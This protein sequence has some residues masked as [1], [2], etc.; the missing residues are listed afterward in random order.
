MSSSMDDASGISWARQAE[1]LKGE[2]EQLAVSTSL[3]DARRLH[4][5]AERK[6]NRYDLYSQG[7]TFENRLLRWL[8]NF[9]SKDR[10]VAMT[11][12]NS[13]TFINQFEMKQLAT[14]TFR[15]IRETLGGQ[16]EV[17]HSDWYSYVD[18]RNQG[19]SASLSR[20]LFI[21]VADDV[22][23]DYFRRYT[24][25]V[26][27]ALQRDNFVEYYKIDSSSR[28]SLPPHDFVFL[29]DQLSGSGTSFL[30]RENGRWEG[31][32]PRFAELWKEEMNRTKIY[33]CPYIQSS[34][35]GAY[36]AD[37]V[38]RWRNSVQVKAAVNVV[39]TMR[40]P[41][42]S[43]LS[44][45]GVT[46][47]VNSEVARLCRK[48]HGAFVDDEHIVKGGESWYGFGRAGLTL[49]AYTNCPNNS[50]PLL[51]HSFGGWF[52]LFPRVRHHHS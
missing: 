4:F 44:K 17:S 14:S 46:I 38:P 5:L 31:K 50:L 19:I 11:I 22:M 8:E 20:S 16:G 6:Y 24:Q 39:P 9:S 52:P 13:L 7:E 42:S 3:E 26:D 28:D 37:T 30:R 47:D 34:V 41:V 48:Y 49:V 18:S 33:Y 25:S 32:L 40:L 43:C 10:N 51:W 45:D 27:P 36:L 35:A 15:G 2:L 1:L 29:L 12:V 21:A 23:F